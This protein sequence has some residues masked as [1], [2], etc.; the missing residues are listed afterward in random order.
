MFSASKSTSKPKSMSGKDDKMS[1]T[2]TL[3][4]QCVNLV[5]N[6]NNQKKIRTHVID[7]LVAYFKYKLGTFFFIII[8]LLAC[9]LVANIFLIG[10][11]IQFR[12]GLRGTFVSTASA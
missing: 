7:P 9:I 1:I 2:D 10:S 5:G 6:E 4:T 8:I 12:S 3:F 11:F